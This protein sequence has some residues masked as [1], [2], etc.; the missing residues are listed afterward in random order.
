MAKYNT[1]FS[2]DE[3]LSIDEGLVKDDPYKLVYTQ[4]MDFDKAKSFADTLLDEEGFPITG[5]PSSVAAAIYWAVHLAEEAEERTGTSFAYSLHSQEE[6]L[7]LERQLLVDGGSTCLTLPDAKKYAELLL[8]FR[9]GGIKLET[10]Q[11]AARLLEKEAGFRVQAIGDALYIYPK[12]EYLNVEREIA[13][14]LKGRLSASSP[15]SGMER[16]VFSAIEDAEARMDA[17]LSQEQ[18]LACKMALTHRLSVI[19][20]GPGT[21]KTQVQKILIDAFQVL[22]PAA[23]IICVAPTG[24][25]AK[26]MSEVT[27]QFAKTIHSF[28]RLRPGETY[29]DNAPKLA[30]DSLVIADEASM[31]DTEL[32]LSL[33]K[34]LSPSATL[35]LAGDVAQ[36]PSIGKG[37]ILKELIESGIVPFTRLTKIFR[38]KDNSIAFNSAKIQAG[39]PVMDYDRNFSFVEAS[40]SDEIALKVAE[41][42][43]TETAKSDS[44]I[45]LTPFREK[46][47]TG[48]NS[49]NQSL[50]LATKGELL[51]VSFA[52]TKDGIRIYKGD[53]VLFLKNKYGLVNGEVGVC[54]EASDDF[55]VCDF[56]GKTI[57]LLPEEFELVIPAYAQTV[58]KSQGSE[59]ETVI[60]VCDPAHK[61]MASKEIMYTA[62]TRGKKKVCVCGDKASFKDMVLSNT[63]GRTSAI[64]S[65]TKLLMQN[66]G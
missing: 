7:G 29:P 63:R 24:Q 56:T 10:A 31:I 53:K 35:V 37:S 49:L 20:G 38:Q 21:G 12:P 60:I 19:T 66:R 34:S 16:D 61:R 17:L 1:I 62:V 30:K 46:T 57:E 27:G 32:F 45:C 65:F 3:L 26:R 55:L 6:I 25:A 13:A 42:Y 4:G 41:L 22:L 28:L 64:G 40:G 5:S 11:K 15:F 9:P 18:T 36:L 54:T 43:K 23:N 59:Y 8:G 50:R 48:V 44:V 33:L 14:Y 51:N 47:K 39:N 52:E 2:A 58:H